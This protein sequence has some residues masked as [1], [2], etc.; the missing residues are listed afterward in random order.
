[1]LS[2]AM[3][4]K[5]VTI[6]GAARSGV[7]AANFLY[8]QG[9]TVI[10]SDSKPKEKLTDYTCK[11]VSDEI[12]LSAAANQM[13]DVKDAEL[14]I[15]SPGIPAEI[16]PVQWAIQS[17]IPVISEVELAFRFSPAPILAITGS[18]GKTTTTTWLGELLQAIWPAPVAVGGNI[19]YPLCDAIQQVDSNGLVIAEISS[20]QLETISSFRPKVAAIL[21]VS[22]NHL[23][24]YP[25]MTEYAEAK[26]RIFEFQTMDDYAVIN[27]GSAELMKRLPKLHSRHV[28]FSTQSLPG[29]GVMVIDNEIVFSLNNKLTRI[30]KVNELPLPGKHN[31]ENALA[32]I[33]I[34]GCAGADLSK[35]K[36]PLLAFK[37][38]EHRVEYV[39]EL[40]GVRYYND[41]KATTV[42]SVMTAVNGLPA[43]I[44]L[45]MGG[46]D[47]G[48]DYSPLRGLLKE[49]VKQLILIG[50][51]R[52][53]IRQALEGS[54]P[55]IE[56][57]TLEEAVQ[58]S[59]KLSA[60]GDS[61]LLSPACASYDMFKDYEERGRVF[62]QLVEGLR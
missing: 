39:R 14:I 47:K 58:Q 1:M 48:L 22:E 13:E 57:D 32:V 4:Q 18:N 15:L 3:H 24:R 5:K 12:I 10:L 35:A 8:K 11:L 20:F 25:G 31:L 26:F 60:S 45:I 51:A 9:A 34:A 59:R 6:L 28:Y 46:K 44:I 52:P 27:I 41:S 40:D 37:G 30:C 55:I 2:K 42:D 62:K 29:E 38:V 50:Q 16:S 54:C 33:A 7:A 17:G 19:G 49:K 56:C 53:L 61:V 21:N 23:D 43:P 36:A